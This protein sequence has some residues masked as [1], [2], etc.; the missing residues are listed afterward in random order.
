MSVFEITKALIEDNR[1]RHRHG[2]R[3]P[4]ATYKD[5][6]HAQGFRDVGFSF[7]MPS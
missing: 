7:I 3:D 1:N 2:V 5:G 6:T 4:S